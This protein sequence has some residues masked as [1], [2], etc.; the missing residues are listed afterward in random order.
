MIKL[1][2]PNVPAQSCDLSHP[3]YVTP[4][5]FWLVVVCKITNGGYVR[6]HHIKFLYFFCLSIHRLEQRDKTPTY[7]LPRPC[8]LIIIPSIADSNYQL[9]VV[10]Q[11][12]TVGT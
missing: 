5:C 8:V 11:D 4:A 10:S 1:R 3:P 12:E 9:I 7:T 2:S 6:P